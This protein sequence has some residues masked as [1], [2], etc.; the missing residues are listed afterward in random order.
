M[1]CHALLSQGYICSQAPTGLFNK[2]S[3]YP[4]YNSATFYAIL[5][6]FLTSIR[7]KTLIF[8]DFYDPNFNTF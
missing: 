5:L 3:R 6:P 2:N 4:C 7:L 1:T 8:R